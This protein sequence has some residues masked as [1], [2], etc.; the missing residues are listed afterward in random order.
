MTSEEVGVNALP[1]QTDVA[2]V[3]AGPVGLT[4]A[5]ALTH[6]GVD[7]VVVDAA[8]QRSAHSK[9]A[10]VHSRTLEVLREVGVATDLVNRGVVVPYFAFKDRDRT[11]LTTDFG[12]LETAYP[13]T[14]MVPQDITE[15]VLDERLHDLGGVVHR[16]WRVTDVSQNDASAVLDLADG[17][18]AVRQLRARYV[19]GADGAHSSIR[20]LLGVEFAGSAFA[21]SFFL[22]DVRMRWRLSREEVQLFF[23]QTG[24][25]VVAPLP[26]GQ[27]RIVA[28][29]PGPIEPAGVTDAQALLDERGPRRQPAVVDEL[30][31]ASNFRVS[32]RVADRY[33]SGRVFLAGDAAHVHSPAGGQGMNT[34]IQDAMNLAWKLALVCSGRAGVELLDSY[35]AVR[36][37]V[38][39]GVVRQT[40]RLTRLAT[41]RG[42]GRR[43]MRNALVGAVGGVPVVRRVMA[44]NLSELAVSYASG[45]GRPGT[46]SGDRAAVEFPPLPPGE[47]VFRLVLPESATAEQVAAIESAGERRSAGVLVH[48]AGEESMAQLVRPDGYLAAV[49]PLDRAQDLFSSVPYVPTPQRPR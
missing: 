25:V 45:R 38:A 3:G 2:I 37:P 9:A 49:A 4:M 48:R 19:I 26:G 34:G 28:T 11:L 14:L 41:L 8:E 10:V 33:R 5:I 24:L 13:Y 18:S 17:G 23:S 21:E 32:H 27:H 44:Q 22:A 12:R 6:Y 29:V 16:P 46:R 7:A 15:A 39:A 42:R 40:H 31:W 30:V 36:R 1:E 43:A 47:P 20:H 35:E